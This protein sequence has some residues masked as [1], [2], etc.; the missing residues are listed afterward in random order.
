MLFG[1][2]VPGLLVPG[3]DPGFEVPGFEPGL[4]IPGLVDPGLVDPPFG[5]TPGFEGESGVL[6]LV[7]GVVPGVAPFGFVVEG[8]VEPG[9]V[10]LPDPAF[11]VGGAVLLPVGGAVELPVGGAEGDDCPGVAE[12]P[13]CA[14]PPGAAPP[15]PAPACAIS[16]VP[17]HKIIDNNISFLED[18]L[19]GLQPLKSRAVAK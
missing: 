2:V 4:D 12:L 19:R 5:A 6:G 11:P 1:L 3:F 14:A 7:F 18:I 9:A 17:Q 13:L 15:P 10:E 8:C 16:Q